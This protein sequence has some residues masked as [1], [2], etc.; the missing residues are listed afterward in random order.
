MLPI[1]KFNFSKDRIPAFYFNR[2]EYKTKGNSNF[3][4]E[5]MNT[6][7]A[8]RVSSQSYVPAAAPK[9]WGAEAWESKLDWK[10]HLQGFSADGYMGAIQVIF[11]SEPGKTPVIFEVPN[12]TYTFGPEAL[13][14]DTLRD[15]FYFTVTDGATGNRNRIL[16]RASKAHGL[17]EIGPTF[18]FRPELSPDKKWILWPSGEIY[19]SLSGKRVNTCNLR[20]FSM[21]KSESVILTRGI[22]LNQFCAWE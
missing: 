17:E 14:Y 7:G 16:L 13:G 2:R 11:K 12:F 6:S 5:H 21:E 15:Y 10:V 8:Y 3:V 1:R 19:S 22:A 9:P 20:L 18:G 4:T